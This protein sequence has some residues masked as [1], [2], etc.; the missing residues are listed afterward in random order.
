MRKLLLSNLLLGVVMVLGM[1][2]AWGQGATTSSMNGTVTDSNGEPIP[3]ATVIAVHTPTNS[4]FG[5]ATDVT[6]TYRLNNM[7][8]GGPYTVTISF[9][10]F[11]TYTRSGV[12]LDLGQTFRLDAAL[13][14]Q[15][16][17]LEAIEVLAGTGEIF[18]GNRSAPETVVND[19]AIQQLPTVSRDLNDFTRLTPLANTNVGI[20][21]AISFGGL[22]NR[23]NSIFIDG[24]PTNDYFGLASN[25]T[26][27]GQTGISPI[28][29][30]A[31]EQF[32]IVLAPYDVRQGGLAGAGISAVT[33]TGSNNFEGSAWYLVS[34]EGLAGKTPTDDAS[35]TRTKLPDFSNKTYGFRLGGPIVK[36]K[37]FFFVLA[38]IQRDETPQPFNIGDYLGDSD[39][40]DLDALSDLVSSRY[41]YDPGDW[42]F[43]SDLL[44]GEK[45]MVNLDYNISDKH[46]LAVR[47]RYTK[48][49]N[50]GP[51]PSTNT[52]IN[53]ANS[54]Q[55][56]PSTANNGT[57][58]LKSNFENS[59]NSFI[60]G[61]NTVRDDR[62]VSGMPFP[63]IQIQD[64]GNGALINLGGEPFSHANVVNQD[65][66]TLTNNLNLYRGRHTITVGTH[67]EYFSIFNLFLPLHPPRYTFSSLAKFTEPAVPE[68]W[69]FLYGH[70]QSDQNIGDDAVSV[71]ADFSTLQLGFYVQDEFQ[72]NDN[73]KLT[74]GLRV[75]I[76]IFLDD[77]PAN[78]QFN[79]TTLPMIEAAG[80]DLQGSTAGQVPSTQLHWSPRFG[81]NWNVGGD[82]TTQL[83]GGFGIFTSRIP[84]VWPGGVYLRN[85]LTSGFTVGFNG[86]GFGPPGSGGILFEPDLNNQPAVTGGPQ[87]DVDLFADD[88]KFPQIFKV[89]LGVDRK[90]P[91]WGLIGTIDLQYTN[92]V[93]DIIYQHVNKPLNPAGTLSGT[94]DDRPIFDNT[95]IDPT[96]NYITLASNT[97][98]GNTFSVT[99]QLQ[100]PFDNGFTGSIA[101]SYTH[102]ESLFD[103]TVFINSSQWQ[104]YHSVTGRN[105][106]AGL[107]RSQF[108]AGSR[109]TGFLSYRKEYA[110]NFA[111]SISLFYNGQSGL[112]FS[113]VYNDNGGGLT[114]DDPNLD[115]ARNLIYVPAS[116]G[117]IIFGQMV[118]D[119]MGGMMVAEASAADAAAQ[120]AALDA[121]ISGDD[122]LSE[123]RGQYAERNG[124]RMPFENIID[125]R[126]AQEFF[127]MSGGRKHTLEVAIDIFN[128]TNFLN[129]DWGRRYQIS[130]NQ[131]FQLINFVGMLPGTNT[132]TFS[133]SDPGDPWNIIQSGVNS[134]R[135]SARFGLRYT[136]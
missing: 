94:P 3:G 52:L 33:R 116:A 6:G 129:K 22:N 91:W 1:Q 92:K 5:N 132:P 117:E 105:N 120:W 54:G 83:R 95:P 15:V 103:G 14:D 89:T 110:R 66:F 72:V 114:N 122:Y 46:K 82:K 51:L 29:I 97:G 123:R 133:F 21:G 40:S 134:A 125:L 58:E 80:Y 7:N 35:V 70:E 30:D 101:Y 56:F 81:F 61:V 2:V 93:N 48:A 99:A 60:F 102:A 37:L 20:N 85:G 57:I 104:E 45:F 111:T 69:L 119:G 19:Y 109:I 86:D 78:S 64:G 41:G 90:L 28:S 43:T 32:Q 113:Y 71:A 106:P 4:Q 47:Y 74:G 130:D 73:L 31:I 23:Y 18:D 8:V 26:N 128:F 25:G 38:E 115:E 11:E 67:N 75:D 17:E 53:F 44:E 65:V 87:G 42:R 10:G 13:S 136:F 118:D 16:T 126:A 108:A 9:V 107:Q 27:G 50:I 59:S 55:F 98:E 63:N 96:Y 131:N 88:F 36:N 76:P 135:W 79:N 34:N 39:A 84:Y 24:A 112:P 62:E 12:Y 68:A 49:E 100:K 121:F 127:I 124:G 77:G